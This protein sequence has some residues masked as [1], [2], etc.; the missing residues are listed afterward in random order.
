MA[1]EVTDE[2]VRKLKDAIGLADLPDENVPVPQPVEYEEFQPLEQ[3]PEPIEEI[4][5]PQPTVHIA[6]ETS[7]KQ[8]F[9]KINNHTDIAA[10]LI[11]TKKDIRATA[12]TISLLTKAEKLKK[13]AIE[14]LEGNLLELDKKLMEIDSKLVAPHGMMESTQGTTQHEMDLM[15]LDSKLESLRSELSEI[16]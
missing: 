16:D 4:R 11:E 14:K 10:E 7:D 12:E 2:D 9:V 3:D 13:E 15:N 1:K 6:P 8:L 5:I